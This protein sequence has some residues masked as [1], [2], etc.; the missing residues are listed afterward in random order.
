M[1]SSG[2]SAIRVLVLDLLQAAGIAGV[3]A[4]VLLL[5]LLAGEDCVLGVDDDDVIAAVNVGGVIGLELA[6]EKVC[7]E[8]SGFAH[9]ACRLHQGRTT[10]G[11]TVSLV[12][13]VVDMFCASI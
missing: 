7:G 9:E 10:C 12:T 5:Q 1:A 3:G 11:S 8:G 4:V 2:F 13:M 6:A